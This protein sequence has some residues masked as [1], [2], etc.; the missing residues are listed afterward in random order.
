M[1]FETPPASARGFSTCSPLV[2]FV[3]SE[4]RNTLYRGVC[5]LEWLSDCHT[6]MIWKSSEKLFVSLCRV[7]NR[8]WNVLFSDDGKIAGQSSASNVFV[9][10]PQGNSQMRPSLQQMASDRL[11]LPPVA[12]CFPSSSLWW[13]AGLIL[14]HKYWNA[15]CITPKFM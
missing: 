7:C 8:N 1:L 9:P 15:S 6:K 5:L 11:W 10:Q 3:I 12:S 2:P 13:T 4:K 14:D